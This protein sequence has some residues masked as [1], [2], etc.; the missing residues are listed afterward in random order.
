MDSGLRVKIRVLSM[1]LEIF[2]LSRIIL[3]KLAFE[4]CPLRALAEQSRGKVVVLA[5][6]HAVTSM[7]VKPTYPYYEANQCTDDWT[8]PARDGLCRIVL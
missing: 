3:P 4:S 1:V 7:F 5:F 8:G 2:L 6:E